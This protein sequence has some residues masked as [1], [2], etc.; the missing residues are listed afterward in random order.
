MSN[1]DFSEIESRKVLGNAAKPPPTGVRSKDRGTV[2]E[3]VANWGGLPGKTG[4]D[5]S[6]GTKKVKAHPVTK[7]I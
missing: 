4:P 2:M 6:D 1:P 7:G 3:K 5:R